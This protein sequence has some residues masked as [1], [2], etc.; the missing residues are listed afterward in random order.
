M[1]LPLVWW[2]WYRHVNAAEG[3]ST[4]QLAVCFWGESRPTRWGVGRGDRNEIT[5]PGAMALS[6]LAQIAGSSVFG[7][8]GES[9]RT[10]ICARARQ[11]CVPSVQESLPCNVLGF[12]GHKRCAQEQRY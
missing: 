1:L 12:G 5:V 2:W 4:A 9:S 3:I 6:N 10:L 8:H 7:F 11:R